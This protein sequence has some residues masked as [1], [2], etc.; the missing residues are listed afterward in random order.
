[1]PLLTDERLLMAGKVPISRSSLSSHWT[2]RISDKRDGPAAKLT[3]PDTPVKL[4][5]F[6]MLDN[7]LRWG[8]VTGWAK[9]KRDRQKKKKEKGTASDSTEPGRK[10]FEITTLKWTSRS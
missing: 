5:V 9:E 6:K 8:P 4:V 10:K 1:M 7:V 2:T 3:W